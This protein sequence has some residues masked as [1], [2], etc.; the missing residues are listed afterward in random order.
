VLFV[1]EQVLVVLFSSYPDGQL[2]MHWELYNIGAEI[3]HDVH[4][5]RLKQVVQVEGQVSQIE[6]LPKYPSGHW[7]TQ[8]VL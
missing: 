1:R 4:L 5:V 2:L 6:L 8:L 3:P 7:V